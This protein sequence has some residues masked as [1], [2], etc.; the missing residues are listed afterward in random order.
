MRVIA[1]CPIFGGREAAVVIDFSPGPGCFCPVGD[2]FRSTEA[3]LL[4]N[5]PWDSFFQI[6]GHDIEQEFQFDL[7]QT[8]VPGSKEAVAALERAEGVFHLCTNAADQ[9]ID[10]SLSERQFPIT[11]GLVHDAVRETASTYRFSWLLY[12]LFDRLLDQGQ[13]LDLVEAVIQFALGD[14][15]WRSRVLSP[16]A[17]GANYATLVVQ[18]SEQQQ[19]DIVATAPQNTG[20]KAEEWEQ[21]KQKRKVEQDNSNQVPH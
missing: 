17:F 5:H 11:R 1:A 19:S 9:A 10:G 3:R 13:T 8:K 6:E 2:L 15:F 21:L 18:M 4:S 14:S 7:G 12:P 16:R 20:M